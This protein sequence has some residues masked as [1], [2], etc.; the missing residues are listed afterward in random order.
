MNE[1]QLCK[2]R[3]KIRDPGGVKLKIAD[4][5]EKI[6]LALGD[7]L[8]MSEVYPEYDGSYHVTPGPDT[9]TLETKDRV[10][11]EKV[12]IDPIPQNYGKI[13]Y[14]GSYITVT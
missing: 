13:T 9:Q 5:E 14:N 2:I 12:V 1:V 6:P 10:L 4:E 7:P 8:I 11:L 3:L